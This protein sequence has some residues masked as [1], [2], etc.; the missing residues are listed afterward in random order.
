[1]TETTFRMVSIKDRKPNLGQRILFIDNGYKDTFM[2]EY[3]PHEKIEIKKGKFIEI[4]DCKTA[5]D[6]ILGNFTHWL[7]PI[8]NDPYSREL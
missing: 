7:E 1:M 6:F 3:L 8:K 4:Q 2:T 5:T